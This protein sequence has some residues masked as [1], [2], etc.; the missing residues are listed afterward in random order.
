M[1]NQFTLLT[2]RRFLPFFLT[3]MLG[4]FN[5]N[6]FKQSLIMALAF[7]GSSWTTLSSSTL[8]NLSA[9]LFILPFFLFS[10]TAGQ[11]SDHGDKARIIRWIKL[12]E[13]LIMLLASAGYLLHH[14]YLLLT[15]LFL[16]GSHSTF[17]GPAKYAILPQVLSESELV[18]GNAL[19]ETG[20][21]MAILIGS[22]LGGI[23]LADTALSTLCSTL[24]GIALTGWLCSLWIPSVTTAATHSPMTRN[25]WIASCESIRFARRHPEL[26]YVLIGSSWFWFFGA[27][28]LTQIPSFCHQV[29]HTGEHAVTLL[30]SLFSI[31]IAL[32]SLLCERFSRHHIEPGLVPLGLT[33]LVLGSVLLYFFATPTP[34]GTPLGIPLLGSVLFTGFC[35]GVYIVP[36]YAFMQHRSPAGHRSG[37][38]AANNILNA[39]FMVGSALV[40]IL[41]LGPLGGSIRG[42]FLLNGLGTLLLGLFLLRRQPMYGQ[43]CLL[44][45]RGQSTSIVPEVAE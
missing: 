34:A 11:L 4:A 21:S 44:L 40:A 18:G 6:V 20:T 41:F 9:G 17:F 26:W 36:L 1:S 2:Y 25:P 31:G 35:A 27:T 38:I 15:A 16:M 28:L 19:V 29:L 13:V 33:G 23:L 8:T 12:S 30:L 32:G 3:Q 14:L 37:V 24:L 45:L 10:A 5:D 39:L 42:L 7:Q 43:R 22:S